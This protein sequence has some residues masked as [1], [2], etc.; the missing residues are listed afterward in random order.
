MKAIERL[1]WWLFAGSAG[2]PSRARIMHALNDRPYNANQ[3]AERLGMDYKTVRHHL[4]LLEKNG[5]ITSMGG[6]YGKMYSLS[7]LLEENYEFFNRIWAR[8]GKN[9]INEE[10]DRK[11]RT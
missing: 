4:G 10:A 11:V 2:G 5:L 3:L 8:I 9:G 7:T 6:R 1:L